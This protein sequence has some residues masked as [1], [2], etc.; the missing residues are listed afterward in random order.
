[1]VLD[2]IPNEGCYTLQICYQGEVREWHLVTVTI[3]DR[4]WKT[5][6]MGFFQ[7]IKFDAWLKHRANPRLS[8]RPIARF[9]ME[10]QRFVCDRTTPP[11]IETLRSK[12]VA[13]HAYGVYAYYV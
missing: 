1:M 10:I 11:I 4:I 2:V 5:L 12:G 6:R 7:K 13:M 8:L 3:C 9:V